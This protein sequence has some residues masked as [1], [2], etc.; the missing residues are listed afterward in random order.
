MHVLDIR[1]RGCYLLHPMCKNATM[2]QVTIM[3]AASKNVLFPDHSHLLTTSTDDL[4]L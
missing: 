4:T 3:L 1:E 2:N